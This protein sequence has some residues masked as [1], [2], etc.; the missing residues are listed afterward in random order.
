M[1]AQAPLLESLQGAMPRNDAAILC[2]YDQNHA[3]RIQLHHPELRYV[4]HLM[5]YYSALFRAH[6]PVDFV[7]EGQ[8]WTKYRALIAPLQ[9]LMTPALAEKL[10]AYVRG[11]GTLVL[12]M[13][14][15]VKDG[16]NIAISDDELPCRVRDLC[17]LT[18]EEYDCLRTGDVRIAWGD[19]RYDG[20]LWSD[21]IR[22]D[23]AEP[24]ARY[25]SEFYAGLPAITVNRYGA[26]AV[27]YVGTQMTPP[28][29]GRFAAELMARAGLR[30][31]IEADADVEA[32]CREKD[33]QK[34]LFVM[35]HSAQERR[36]RVPEGWTPIGGETGALGAYGFRVYTGG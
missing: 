30:L 5:T 11:G 36:V 14:C 29:A 31:L 10:H 34:W 6:V 24:L 15:G 4:D 13:R 19:A 17:G 23:T 8:D 32:V 27:Y 35:N 2:S 7:H 26:G 16:D 22:V 12:D 20:R 9:F 25:D 21:L 3:L 18:V 33:G 28:L 1:K